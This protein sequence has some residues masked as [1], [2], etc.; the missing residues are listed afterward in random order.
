M[1]NNMLHANFKYLGS[2][3][4]DDDDD[5]DDDDGEEMQLVL[6]EWMNCY[7]NEEKQVRTTPEQD[8]DFRH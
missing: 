2:I 8:C 6:S 3:G 4:G 7:S 5:D 1:N